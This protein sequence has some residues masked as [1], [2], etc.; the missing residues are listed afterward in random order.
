MYFP[1]CSSLTATFLVLQLNATVTVQILMDIFS[2]AGILHCGTAG[3]SN[4]SISFGDVSVPK[5]EAFTGAW[6]WKV[7]LQVESASLPHLKM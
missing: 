3:S 1:S 7:L 4:D 6:T 2:V 5:L